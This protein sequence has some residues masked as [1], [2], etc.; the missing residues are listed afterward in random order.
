MLDNKE[1][2]I[3]VWNNIL[4]TPIHR[5]LPKGC[6]KNCLPKG[7]WEIAYDIED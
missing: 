5:G 7:C 2:S 1:A 6:W 3:R 4:T